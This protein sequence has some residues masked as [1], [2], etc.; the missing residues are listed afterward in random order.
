[1]ADHPKDEAPAVG[2]APTQIF[3]LP[4]ILDPTL[5]PDVVLFVDADGQIITAYR[6]PE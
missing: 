6:L 4:L 3:G 2:E 5:P 1:M